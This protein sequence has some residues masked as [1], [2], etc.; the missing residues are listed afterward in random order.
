[1]PF[2]LK[3]APATFQR[4][5]NTITG[6]LNQCDAYIDDV[7]VATDEWDQQMK[8]IWMLF[9]SLTQAKFTIN[10][11][12]SEFVKATSLTNS[13]QILVFDL[14]VV[15]T[16]KT[17]QT[18][19]KALF[20]EIHVVVSMSQGHMT[21]LMKMVDS[22]DA[23]TK[24]MTDF[25][26]HSKWL[27]LPQGT[28]VTTLSTQNLE[29]VVVLS[30]HKTTVY[31][32]KSINNGKTQYKGY[33]IDILEIIADVLNFSYS[34]TEP[35]DQSWGLPVNNTYNGIVGQLNRTEV[36]LAACDLIMNDDRSEFI[37]YIYPPISTEYIDV[38]YK[39]H[40]TQRSGSLYLLALPL[41]P[42]VYLVLFLM[43]GLCPLLFAL[44]ES[45][46]IFLR[47][48][49]AESQGFSRYPTNV[50]GKILM[51]SL[52]ML[53]MVVTTVYCANLVAA[54]SAQ[55]DV[56][57]FSDLQ[58]LLN[59]NYSVGMRPTGI[60]SHILKTRDPSSLYGR[61]WST[62]K[63]NDPVFLESSLENHLKRVRREKYAFV[64]YTSEL[65]KHMADDCQLQKL[66]ER[67]FFTQQAFGLPK[68]SP[69]KADID[70]M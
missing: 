4:L 57:L 5:I 9:D 1:M 7:I 20:P 17:L 33:A 30:H 18:I 31:T 44:F 61:L 46:D 70:K 23:N 58:G 28:I 43:A 19:H 41:R 37:D 65:E 67:L 38:L 47:Q 25:R 16:K 34:I 36:D 45:A 63:A 59:S 60:N 14:S 12:K 54:L 40:D 51:T 53:L 29:N 42:N 3:N 52:W 50:S 13:H 24:G 69:L 10:L 56:K 48:T 26:H 32:M 39:K 22:F 49:P 6:R 68:G 66:G 55:K 64:H 35:Q 15:D 27:L 21:E 8:T 11:T 2:G 62:I